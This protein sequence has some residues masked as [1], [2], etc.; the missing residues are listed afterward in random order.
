MVVGYEGPLLGNHGRYVRYLL[1]QLTSITNGGSGDRIILLNAPS[2][3]G[4]SRIIREFYHRL[5]LSQ[6]SSYWPPLEPENV[7][8]SPVID[9]MARRKVIGPATRDFIW[10]E[11]TLPSFSWWSFNCEQMSTGGSIDLIAEGKQQWQTHALPITIAARELQ[12][13]GKIAKRA[14]SVGTKKLWDAFKE[15]GSDLAIDALLGTIDFAV[16]GAHSLIGWGQDLFEGA[17]QKQRENNLLQSRVD[18]GLQHRE[19]LA[20]AVDEFADCIRKFA[21]PGLPAIVVVEDLH[22]LND[23]FADF[24]DKATSGDEP[25]LV[26]GTVWPEA[27]ARHA[28]QRFRSLTEDR[29]V[30]LEIEQLSA[31]DLGELL[32]GHAQQ[33]D[34]EVLLALTEKLSTPLDVN[35]WLS[36]PPVQRH[37]R[38]NGGQLIPTAGDIERLPETL[39]T[40]HDQRWNELDDLE[41][42]ALTLA[43]T[44]NPLNHEPLKPFIAEVLAPVVGFI[45]D[46]DEFEI[47]N[48]YKRLVESASWCR[49]VG[50]TTLFVEESLVRAVERN[51]ASVLMDADV[52]VA[53]EE[54]IRVVGDYL[55]EHRNGHTSLPA[56]PDLIL[57]A[58]WYDAWTSESMTIDEVWIAVQELLA[59]IS[60][61]R[62]D[63]GDAIRRAEKILQLRDKSPTELLSFYMNLDVQR[64]E[65][66]AE[67]GEIDRAIRGIEEAGNHLAS[68]LGTEKHRDVLLVK[69]RIPRILAGAGHLA[70]AEAV[71]E[72][73]LASLME[74]LGPDD[75]L[76]HNERA[77]FLSISPNSVEAAKSRQQQTEKLVD[78]GLLNELESIQVRIGSTS[79]KARTGDRKAIN[80]LKVLIGKYQSHSERDH[81]SAIE[82]KNLLGVVLMQH[83]LFDEA[84]PILEQALQEATSEF[85]ETNDL[86]IKISMNLAAVR[87][88]L[89]DVATALPLLEKVAQ[90]RTGKFGVAHKESLTSLFLLG[91][92]LVDSHNFERAVQLLEVVYRERSSLLGEHDPATLLARREIAKARL[93]LGDASAFEEIV[94]VLKIQEQVLGPD[95]RHCYTTREIIQSIL[96]NNPR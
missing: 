8:E 64:C 53:R 5:I 13:P 18:L 59:Q 75:P 15:E 93:Y 21:V 41:R 82:Y 40:V 89:G 7:R 36:L 81:T 65:W 60:A 32:L 66:L 23:E 25:V 30:E 10:K 43:V 1:E 63:Y 94:N 83:H 55:F 44:L 27:T 71:E 22:L 96:E 88:N 72:Q 77:F 90:Y 54:L 34:P 85:K 28:Y 38:V 47:L 68:L 50:P 73:V 35:L 17:Q 2:G 46:L 76:V 61:N 33:T 62:L 16:P 84:L 80:D 26:V 12:A 58:K 52:F 6:K 42:L 31:A 78:S 67:H 37:I 86:T 48:L 9:P 19:S 69:S 70:T 92:A 79:A 3:A 29:T 87:Q 45:A 11:N 91:K 57:L 39:R 4:K 49:V 24:L 74:I 20:L 14:F 51:R 56:S 95:H